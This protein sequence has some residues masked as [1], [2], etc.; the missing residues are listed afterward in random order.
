MLDFIQDCVIGQKKVVLLASLCL[1]Y[2]QDLEKNGF[3]N[4]E[5]IRETLK[6][7]LENHDICKLIAFAKVKVPISSKFLFSC[8]ILYITQ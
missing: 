5:Y 8:L 4:P 3:A 1:L 2:I 7:R 6:A